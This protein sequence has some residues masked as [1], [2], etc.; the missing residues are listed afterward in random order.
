MHLTRAIWFS[1]LALF[2]FLS[3]GLIPANAQKSA[4]RDVQVLLLSDIHLDPFLDPG[5]VPQ[6]ASAPASRWHAILDASASADQE[7]RMAILEKTCHTRG[8]DT[9]QELFVSTL[10]QLR[11]EAAHSRFA[12]ISGDLLAHSFDC[13]FKA[14]MP[15]ATEAAYRAFTVKTMDYILLQV[16][17]ALPGVPVYPVLGNNDSG[18]G[19]YQLD[20]HSA[21]LAE[22]APAFVADLAPNQ[23]STAK[24]AFA[25]FGNYSVALPAPFQHMRIV[26]IDNLF[27]ARKYAGCNG[28]P[29]PAAAQ[30]QLAWLTAQLK[31]ARAHGDKLW[32]V[33]HLPPG[34]DPYSTVFHLRNVCAGQPPDPFLSSSALP[35]TLAPYAEQI[36]LAIFAHTH[37]DEMRLIPGTG[38][39]ASIAIKLTPSISPINGNL[40]SYIRA[41]VDPA[42]GTMVDYTVVASSDT[43]GSAWTQA[44]TFSEAYRQPAY[45]AATVSHLIAGFE[46]D[47]SANSP[48]SQT[49]IHHYYLKGGALLMSLFWPQYSCS[50][51]HMEAEGYRRCVCQAQ[52]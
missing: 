49:Y 27:E 14:T 4:P 8:R 51:D 10:R 29:N 37:M 26:G 39:Q 35:N 31:A 36:P 13:K 33:G 22:A 24:D 9:S 28:Q 15:G 32:I 12:V 41:R 20:P 42:S 47:K 40:P 30:Q 45:T 52:E 23:R 19:D 18:C 3:S 44:Y 38:K 50:L 2:A 25:A 7:A 43:K 11:T 21:F 46:A 34:I 1:Y 6:L 17:A 48:A 16:R 5:K